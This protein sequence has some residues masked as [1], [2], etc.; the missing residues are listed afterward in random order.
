MKFLA[1]L[2]LFVLVAAVF[3]EAQS[4]PAANVKQ[5]AV[6]KRGK[7]N[8]ATAKRSHKKAHRGRRR[9]G[10]RRDEDYSGGLSEEDP[11]DEDLWDEDDGYD[12]YDPC[13][14]H[15]WGDE[16]EADEHE[17]HHRRHKKHSSLVSAQ[18]ESV[19]R[20]LTKW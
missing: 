19:H 17:D 11:W 13:G 10:H 5:L 8:K 9:H 4:E 18:N 7:S 20:P 6:K 12:C 2:C 16:H 1:W 15:G 3:C 14:C